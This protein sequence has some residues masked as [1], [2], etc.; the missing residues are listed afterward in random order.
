MFR[1][2]KGDTQPKKFS[3]L[4]SY[5]CSF[6]LSFIQ[7]YFPCEFSHNFWPKSCVKFFCDGKLKQRPDSIDSLSTKRYL[8]RKLKPNIT[9]LWNPIR[10]AEFATPLSVIGWE[11]WVTLGLSLRCNLRLM[12]KLSNMFN[13][14]FTQHI[15]VMIKTQM[16][17]MLKPYV[18]ISGQG[19]QCTNPEFCSGLSVFCRKYNLL[20]PPGFLWQNE[21]FCE[22]C[23]ALSL[24]HFQE[25]KNIYSFPWFHKSREKWHRKSIFLVVWTPKFFN[26][27]RWSLFL[28]F[29][30]SWW[31]N[32][33]R[34]F[35]QVLKF[36]MFLV[37]CPLL[38]VCPFLF[39]LG[40]IIKDRLILGTRKDQ[41]HNW[42]VTRK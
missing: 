37:C 22:Q 5:W 29:F 30:D 8:Q 25:L 24:R 10:R 11:I 28:D 1:L 20:D 3:C 18:S 2:S 21:Q 9:E 42:K 16:K 32:L 26:M 27:V 7:F 31:P 12:L 17:N 19:L 4:F 38:F 39:C 33:G 36:V 6:Q 15:N 40:G 14:N 34:P 35:L 23:C 13:R 41:C